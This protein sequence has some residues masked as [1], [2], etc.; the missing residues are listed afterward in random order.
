[1]LFKIAA[2]LLLSLNPL[3]IGRA[4]FLSSATHP[5]RSHGGARLSVLVLLLVY[6]AQYRA[7]RVIDRNAHRVPTDLS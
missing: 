2:R 6:L 1:M 4:D 3:K 7:R 5:P